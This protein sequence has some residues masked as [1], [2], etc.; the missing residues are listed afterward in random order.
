[1]HMP[2]PLVLLPMNRDYTARL[3]WG[4]IGVEIDAPFK[5]QPY[6]LPEPSIT[7]ESPTSGMSVAVMNGPRVEEFLSWGTDTNK[8][9]KATLSATYRLLVHQNA[10][11]SPHKLE[12]IA[13]EK[14]TLAFND[15]GKNKIWSSKFLAFGGMLP[16]TLNKLL[17]NKTKEFGPVPFWVLVEPKSRAESIE[18]TDNSQSMI[19]I[20]KER[21]PHGAVA[22][23]IV[24]L[25]PR[26]D[27]LSAQKFIPVPRSLAKIH[28]SDAEMDV[29]TLVNAGEHSQPLVEWRGKTYGDKKGQLP[30]SYKSPS[31]VE[32]HGFIPLDTYEGKLPWLTK[33]KPGGAPSP[34]CIFAVPSYNM[35]EYAPKFEPMIPKLGALSPMRITMTNEADGEALIK[36]ELVRFY[37]EER[38]KEQQDAE[39]MERIKSKD[40][41]IFA[42]AELWLHPREEV[43]TIKSDKDEDIPLPPTREP[44]FEMHVVPRAYVDYYRGTVAGNGSGAS[45]ASSKRARTE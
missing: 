41:T 17:V 12:S 22:G 19:D 31:E 16:T 20:R 9:A 32:H 14:F 26:W 5:E 21:W 11:G 33:D 34:W 8:R 29:S 3:D 23:T 40:E 7:L 38:H 37:L 44:L 36:S 39:L 15:G 4:D 6:I 30:A 43:K 27:E 2:E 18:L 28:Y 35:A 25:I 13:L 10:H 1:M 45:S 24:S 42:E